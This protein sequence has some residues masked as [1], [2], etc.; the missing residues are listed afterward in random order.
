MWTTAGAQKDNVLQFIQVHQQ[1][2][3][4]DYR[5]MTSTEEWQKCCRGYIYSVQIVLVVFIAL[6]YTVAIAE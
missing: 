1:C 5:Q 6:V 3:H 2:N 4:S